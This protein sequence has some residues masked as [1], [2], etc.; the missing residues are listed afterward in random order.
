MMNEHPYFHW[1]LLR[2]P[3]QSPQFGMGGMAGMGGMTGMGGM[4]GMGGMPGMGGMGGMGA[5][6]F[7]VNRILRH[8]YVL[9]LKS[10]F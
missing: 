8:L 3:L 1:D 7:D 5:P 6:F 4:G 10:L 9:T 2:Q